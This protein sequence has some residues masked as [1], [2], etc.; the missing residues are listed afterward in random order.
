MRPRLWPIYL[1]IALL[2][3]IFIAFPVHAAPELNQFSLEIKNLSS[4]TVN[5]E[6]LDYPTVDFYPK[7]APSEMH[8][9]IEFASVRLVVNDYVKK[10]WT[11]QENNTTF[12]PDSYSWDLCADN[13]GAPS[14]SGYSIDKTF[15]IVLNGYMKGELKQYILGSPQSIKVK[16]KY[17]CGNPADTDFIFLDFSKGST[18]TNNTFTLATTFSDAELAE[19]NYR[20]LLYQTTP[21]GADGQPSTEVKTSF[22]GNKVT[23]DSSGSAKGVHKFVVRGT[24]FAP[25]YA[26]LSSNEVSVTVGTNGT[27]DSSTGGQGG[28]GSGTGTGTGN[29]GNATLDPIKFDLPDFSALKGLTGNALRFKLFDLIVSL[30]IIIVSM[31]AGI[32][33]LYSGI[34][35]ALSFGDQAKAEKA[36]KNLMWAALGIVVL[37]L[38]VIIINMVSRLVNTIK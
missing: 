5:V 17:T 4:N 20:F 30:I 37:S 18:N 34:S 1:P 38:S 22:T 2:L 23:W 25:G 10:D 19:A 9:N 32:A 36:K 14:G 16:G 6:G 27:V 7:F 3:A 11:G 35:Y 15:N 33:F 28:D 24:T 12:S 13:S 26:D 31:F 29:T 8:Y 21:V